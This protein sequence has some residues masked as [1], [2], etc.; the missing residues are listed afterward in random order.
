MRE[1]AQPNNDALIAYNVL[2][3]KIITNGFCTL[4][5]ACEAVCP[6]GALQVEAERVNR[7]HDCSKG[8]GPMPNLL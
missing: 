6:T 4:C 8:P 5:G 1:M 3:K 7:L 2:K